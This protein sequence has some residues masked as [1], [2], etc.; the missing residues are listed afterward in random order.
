ML[1]IFSSF[2]SA[3]TDSC[4]MH[5]DEVWDG[6]FVRDKNPWEIFNFKPR[7]WGSIQPLPLLWLILTSCISYRHMTQETLICRY[8]DITLKLLVLRWPSGQICHSAMCLSNQQ[9]EPGHDVGS[10]QLGPFVAGEECHGLLEGEGQSSGATG[11]GQAFEVPP[12]HDR[13]GFHQLLLL[14]TRRE[15]LRAAGQTR[16][17]LRLFQ[18]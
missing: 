4:L 9:S 3:H 8:V 16:L 6:W 18:G 15:P 13:R 1:I 17:F 12:G 5:F 2:L 10:G 11:A 14:Q 7:D